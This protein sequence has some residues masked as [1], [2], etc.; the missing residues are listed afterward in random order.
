[1]RVGDVTVGMSE[2][3]AERGVI[4]ARVI[5]KLKKINADVRCTFLDGN[6]LNSFYSVCVLGCWRI[7]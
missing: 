7:K 5:A 1:M 3:S 4:M 2:M 6:G